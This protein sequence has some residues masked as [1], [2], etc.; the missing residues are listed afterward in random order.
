MVLFSESKRLFKA[1][2]LQGNSW[3]RGRANLPQVGSES[4]LKFSKRLKKFGLSVLSNGP[5][6]QVY[7]AV[8]AKAMAS[9]KFAFNFLF[10]M[11]SEMKS[12]CVESR[13]VECLGFPL[14]AL[15]AS[16]DSNCVMTQVLERKAAP[17]GKAGG[18]SS[19]SLRISGEFCLKLFVSFRRTSIQ[20]VAQDENMFVSG[21]NFTSIS[22]ADRS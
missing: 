18:S 22:C 4:C 9:S 20:H 10:E 16:E 17:T 1:F 6:C 2:R 7:S 15:K 14:S 19:K 8:S 11:N 12:A 21:S 13:N 5:S 3:P